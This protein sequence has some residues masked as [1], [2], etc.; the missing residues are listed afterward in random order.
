MWEQR[1]P[2]EVTSATL[3]HS[4]L[5]ITK[6]IY[7]SFRPQILRSGADAMDRVPSGVVGASWACCL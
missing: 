5:N 3:H 1:V 6:D 7:M 2:I 4:G